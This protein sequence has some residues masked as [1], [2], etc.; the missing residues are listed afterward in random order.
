VKVKNIICVVVFLA[1]SFSVSFAAWSKKPQFRWTQLYRYDV[2]QDDHRLYTNRLSFTL[3]YLNK[4][5]EPLFKLVPYFEFRRNIEH[6]LWE[7]KELGVEIGKDITPWL[8][9]GAA[10]QRGWMKE[11]YRNKLDYEKRDYTESEI[12]LLF[13]RT[14]LNNK[15]V[16]LKG[17]VLEEYTYD[18]SEGRGMRNEVAIGVIMP[19]GKY[20]EADIHWRHIDRIGHYDSDTPEI[21]LTLVF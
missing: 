2:R 9:I 1:F 18:F 10:I 20:V 13:S 8:Y 6:D 16:N 7:R 4:E 17:F 19:L 3:D 11:D 21:A 15:Y 14:L 12:K 5:E